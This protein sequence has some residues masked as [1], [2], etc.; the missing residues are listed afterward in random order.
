MPVVAGRA[1]RP[2]GDRPWAWPARAGCARPPWRVAAPPRRAAPTATAAGRRSLAKCRDPLGVEVGRSLVVRRQVGEPAL[3]LGG[4]GH[5]VIEV[6]AVL[7]AQ[8]AQQLAPGAQR[9]EPLGVVFDALGDGPDVV[10]D[11]VEIGV[12]RPQPRRQITVR[13]TRSP[14][15]A[16]AAPMASRAPPSSRRAHRSPAPRLTVRHRVG[17]LALVSF[18]LCVFVGVDDGGRRQ[19]VDLEPVEVDLARPGPLVAA[20]LASAASISASG[21][22]PPGARWGR[23]CRSGRVRPLRGHRHERLVGVLTVEVDDD[24]PSS[25]SE[26]TVARRPSR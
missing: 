3:G 19:F 26:V 9:R 7:A 22:A 17:E 23:R 20:E 5:D 25:A 1:R 6:I 12:H 14:S 4:V 15:A 11:V 8:V 21:P 24:A 13:R 10:G 18:E 16:S 2:R